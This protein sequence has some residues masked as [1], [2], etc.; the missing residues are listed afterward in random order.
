MNSETILSFDLD[1]MLMPTFENYQ[2]VREA[3]VH[4]VQRK[5]DA[6][7]SEEEILGAVDN[8]DEGLIDEYGFDK[9]RSILAFK[10]G[11][12]ELGEEYGFEVSQEDLRQ[13]EE[14]GRR[15]YL[16]EDEYADNGFEEG[17]KEL[18]EYLK[19]KDVQMVLLTL[20]DEEI[21]R[22]KIRAL[23]LEKY[24]DEIKIMEE[25]SAEE[26]KEVLDD[27]GVEPEEVVHAGDSMRHDIIPILKAGGKAIYYNRDTE[28]SINNEVEDGIDKDRFLEVESLHEAR[29]KLGFL[30]EEERFDELFGTGNAY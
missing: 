11:L 3:F 4:W 8:V 29:E 16:S 9:E 22:R 15:V 13:A 1:D 2:L 28:W 30:V 19:D 25:K 23:G 6:H 18:L 14:I 21:Q 7:L 12:E 27:L 5:F 10:R 17:G 20:G 26:Y 24:F